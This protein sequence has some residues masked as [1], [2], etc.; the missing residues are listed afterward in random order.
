MWN[1]VKRR[2]QSVLPH[3]LSR[4]NRYCEFLAL[5]K[6]EPGSLDLELIISTKQLSDNRRPKCQSSL[7]YRQGGERLR[8]LPGRCANAPDLLLP[9]PVFW[10]FLSSSVLHSSPFLFL[11]CPQE[12]MLLPSSPPGSLFSDRHPPHLSSL[13]SLKTKLFIFQLT[14]SSQVYLP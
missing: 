4:T 12:H 6:V 11:F 2:K 8:V 13:L 10:C 9:P 7:Y 5:R 1:I 14:K 3:C